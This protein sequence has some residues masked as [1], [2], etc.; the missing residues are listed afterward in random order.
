MFGT[1][2]EQ[3]LYIG[4]SEEKTSHF[5]YNIGCDKLTQIIIL[6]SKKACEKYNELKQLGRSV[7]LILHN[8]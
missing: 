2:N 7:L 4:F 6:D 5:I 3:K 1:G 8:E